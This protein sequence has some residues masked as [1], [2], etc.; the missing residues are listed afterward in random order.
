[1]QACWRGPEVSIYQMTVDPRS[2]SESRPQNIHL[3]FNAPN[4]K[5]PAQLSAKKSHDVP[6]RL[7]RGQIQPTSTEQLI[8]LCTRRR[9]L[10]A[11]P[12]LRG[13]KGDQVYR[14][15]QRQTNYELERLW[16]GA[17]SATP[18]NTIFIRGQNFG[19]SRSSFHTVHSTR[20][21]CSIECNAW[22][23]CLLQ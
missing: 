1:M 4:R 20:R 2:A 6:Q 15:G 12:V 17:I 10:A 14:A 3:H 21:P 5:S 22:S 23:I 19:H 13:L 9:P 7:I 18:N 16:T 11:G 8:N